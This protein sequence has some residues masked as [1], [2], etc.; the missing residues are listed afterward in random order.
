MGMEAS[1]IKEMIKRHNDPKD[2][3]HIQQVC[4]TSSYI[5]FTNQCDLDYDEARGSVV[6]TSK[7]LNSKRGIPV[8]FTPIDS[9]DKIE[10]TGLDPDEYPL[11]TGKDVIGEKEYKKMK[12]IAQGDQSFMKPDD[13]HTMK[14]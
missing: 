14:R 7:H 9:L 1:F 4:T 2:P 8:T 3:L 13:D 11:L 10:V 6:Y 12:R 5:I